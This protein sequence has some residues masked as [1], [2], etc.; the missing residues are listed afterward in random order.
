MDLCS[1]EETRAILNVVHYVY[2]GIMIVVPIVLIFVGMF[3]LAKAVTA[4]DEKAVKEAQQTLIKKA[5]AAGLVF[6]VTFLVGLIMRI[7][8]NDEY[9]ECL[10]CITS[11]RGCSTSVSND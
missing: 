3:D 5:I 2:L 8:G 6:L 1:M 9:K 10:K 7:V 11:I 4:K